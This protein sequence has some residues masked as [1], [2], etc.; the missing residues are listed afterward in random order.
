MT[1]GALHASVFLLLLTLFLFSVSLV[2]S[3]QR[4]RASERVWCA[5][6]T[7]LTAGP[8][9]RNLTPEQRRLRAG[10]VEL[11]HRYGCG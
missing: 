3:D 10:L 4:L 9:P 6:L 2:I 1:R 7:P 8:P 5:I 11:R